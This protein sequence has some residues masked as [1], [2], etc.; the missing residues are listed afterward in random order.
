MDELE[1]RLRVVVE[2]AHHPRVL[3]VGHAQVVEVLL[4]RGVVGGRRRR[5]VVHQQ[6]SGGDEGADLGTLVVE[7]PQRVELRAAPGGLVEVEPGEEVAQQLPVGRAAVGVAEGGQ[8]QPVPREPEGPEALV[9]DRDHLGVQR[10]VVHADR[11]DPHL[12]QLPVAARLRALVA[13]ERARVAQLHRQSGPVETVLDHGPHHPGGA[14]RTQGHRAVAAVGEGVHLLADDVGRLPDPPRVEA[15]VLEHRQLDQPVAG[16]V[17]RGLQRVPD[18]LEPG[19]LGREV[20]RDALGRGERRRPFRH[21]A[22]TSVHSGARCRARCRAR[23]CDGH[24]PRLRAGPSG[25]DSARP[26]RYGFDARSRPIVVAGP[27]PGS[28]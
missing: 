13:E 19:G 22:R 9:R 28:T 20:L 18:V 1:G 16:P 7:H 23:S 21:G 8:L 2:P 25:I 24:S 26:T 3:D 17:G 6:R 11:L 27:C 5:E 14:L 4:H 12:L 15:G 10:G